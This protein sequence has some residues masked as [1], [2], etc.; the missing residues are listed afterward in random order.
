MLPPGNTQ[1]IRRSSND[2]TRYH[3][4]KRKQ[5]KRQVR[6][7]FPAVPSPAF[8][9]L[10]F[11]PF[12]ASGV[13]NVDD[14]GDDNDDGGGEDVGEDDDYDDDCDDD[15]D[16]D[17][18][19]E[20][21]EEEDERLH[22]PGVL[23]PRLIPQGGADGGNCNQENAHILGQAWTAGYI[24]RIHR[25]DWQ[26]CFISTARMMGNKEMPHLEGMKRAGN[27]AK[28]KTLRQKQT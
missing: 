28:P 25:Q 6:G 4:G 14:D 2:W 22:V 1:E 10:P 17:Y 23:G 7:L 24:G 8:F 15:C 13:G 16:Y 5:D 3:D 11:Q 19:Y 21:E 9:F 20:E 27:H 18:D 12:K 26:E